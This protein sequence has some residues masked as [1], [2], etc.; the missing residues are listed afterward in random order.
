MMRLKFWI[1]L[2][3]S[4]GFDYIFAQNTLNE[5]VLRKYNYTEL[6]DSFYDYYNSDKVVESKAIASFYIKKAKHERNDEQITQGYIIAHLSENFNNAIRYLDSMIIMS[7]KSSNNISM[8]K[9][10]LLKG[11]LY[12]KYDKLK[13]SLDNY[14]LGLKYAKINKNQELIDATN[15]NIAYL[16]CYIGKN[17]EAARTFRYYLYNGKF[18]ADKYQQDQTRVSLVNCYL[19]INKLDSAAIF[20]N[21]GLK[22]LRLNKN[23]Y[24]LNQYLYLSGVLDL[25]RGKYEDA[26]ENLLKSYNYF[27]NI[28]DTNVNYILYSLG[29]VYCRLGEN[30]K[31]FEYFTLLDSN[32]KKNSVTFLELREVYMYLINYSKQKDDKEKQLYFIDRFFKVDKKLDEQFRYLSMELPRKYDTPKL[33]EEKESI[34]SDLENRKIILYSSISILLLL[35]LLVLYL[36]YKSKK[37]EKRQIK[38]AQD[39]INSIAKRNLEI[40]DIVVDV[41]SFQKNELI[42]PKLSFNKLEKQFI[43]DDQTK[44]IK[45]PKE[46]EDKTIKTIPE[47]VIQ[48]I[49]KE[50]ENFESNNLFLKKG[51]T[52]VSLAKGMKTNTTYLSEIINTH[53]GKNFARY[54]ND[55]RIE[56]ALNKL[57]MDK[58]FRSYKLSVIAEELGYNNEQAFSLA[59]KKKTGTSLSIYLKEIEKAN[60]F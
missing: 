3:L 26:K 52:L 41:A 28:N 33:L 42:E 16:N 15:M 37:T 50:L 17:L 7:K 20:I 48:S 25:K 2:F 24:T 55:L 5:D 40:P 51:I 19:E 47:D 30:N 56:Y 32:V 34:I 60:N 38:I 9:V 58:R 6:R 35:L 23:Q 54:L 21:E 27:S 18:T 45:L 57:I 4:L 46:I 11:N 8:A 59:F 39:L 12:Y 1:L 49:L 10:Y 13:F 36:Y 53:K 31:A 44:I 29:K 22:S 14:I 43:D